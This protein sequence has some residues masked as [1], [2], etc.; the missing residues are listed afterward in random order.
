[1]LSRQLA[2]SIAAG[3]AVRSSARPW[4]TP[5]PPSGT[6][7]DRVSF[8]IALHTARDQLIHAA[9]IIAD[10]VIDPIETIGRHVLASL[11]PAP[12]LRVSPRIVKRAISTYQARG[13]SIDRTSYKPQSASTSWPPNNL[14]AGI[15]PYLHGLAASP[16]RRAA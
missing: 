16:P 6:D 10:T 12:R 7:P 11:L 3:V 1:M 4:L 14:T 15:S 9:C 13:P 5:P 8:T 2:R